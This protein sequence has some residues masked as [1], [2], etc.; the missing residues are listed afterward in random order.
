MLVSEAVPVTGEVDVAEGDV[1]LAVG[2]N[3]SVLV[4]DVVE[5]DDDAPEELLVPEV[6]S[7]C[8]ERSNHESCE[9]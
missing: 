7:D 8:I 9:A 2:L 4:E 1:V 3:R 5:L 6:D